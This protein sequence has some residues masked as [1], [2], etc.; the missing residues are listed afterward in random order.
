MGAGRARRG[1]GLTPQV[2]L[3]H[4]GILGQR[5]RRASRLDPAR[6]QHVAA[7]GELSAMWAF[8]S[9]SRTWCPPVDARARCGRS[10]STKTG[11]RPIDGSSSSMQPRAVIRARPTPA[12]AARR[13]RACRPAGLCARPGAGRGRRPAPGPGGP[14]PVPAA[15]GGQ[16]EVFQDRQVGEDP[17]GPRGR[18]ACPARRPGGPAVGEVAA[19]E[20]DA[21]PAGRDQ[22]GDGPQRRGLAR[23]V[24]ADQVT[25]SPSHHQGD[26]VE[27]LDGP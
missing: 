8:C 11:A 15:V 7:I 10:P 13:R 18:G 12:S 21:S 5:G 24:G 2:G 16:V 3:P 23:A 17:A 20:A 1:P 25:I 19:R 26:A 14:G 9:T 4:L 27:R 22:A 6:L